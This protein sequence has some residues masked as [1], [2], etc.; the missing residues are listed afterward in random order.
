MFTPLP[1]FQSASTDAWAALTQDH[2]GW[3]ATTEI[4]ML[5]FWRLKSKVSVKGLSCVCSWFRDDGFSL[6]P[7]VRKGVRGP[8]GVLF[9]SL[10]IRAIP[11]WAF[12]VA[13]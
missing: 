1:A 2:T 7:H 13:Q 6:S 8:S 5:R 12:Q 10:S 4:Y 3:E 11:F 9:G